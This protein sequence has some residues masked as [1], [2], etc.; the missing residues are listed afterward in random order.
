MEEDLY[1]RILSDLVWSQIT[2]R[3]VQQVSRKSNI[4]QVLELVHIGQHGNLKQTL[5]QISTFAKSLIEQS[6]SL[7]SKYK[8]ML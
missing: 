1:L 8:A 6:T 4:Q 3:Q 7:Y 2:T 5:M